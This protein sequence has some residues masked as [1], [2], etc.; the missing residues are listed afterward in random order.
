MPKIYKFKCN[1][2]EFSLPRGWGG[3]TYVKDDN[4]KKII[5]PHP[6]EHYMIA[7]VLKINTKDAS[8]W[9][10]EEFGKISPETKKLIDE[11][12]GF[13]SHCLCLNCLEQFDTDLKREKRVCPNCRS[14][15]V[16]TEWELKY[17]PCPKCKK[18]E[19][20]AEWTGEIS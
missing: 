12:T 7:Q 1:Q 16:K 4:G 17:Q 20:E 18:G 6:G 2:C 11:R 14:E 9:L 13:D 3:Y 10:L 8:A 19:I 5:C 15:N